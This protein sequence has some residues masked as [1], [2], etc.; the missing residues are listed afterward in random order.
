[1][2]QIHKLRTGRWARPS[3][4]NNEQPT[5]YF[6]AHQAADLHFPAYQA[7]QR[8]RPWR[9]L[10]GL[11]LLACLL[12]G[13]GLV[14]AAMMFVASPLLLPG[15]Q[16]MG[17]NVGLMTVND[18][19]VALGIEWQQQGL[20]LESD[21]E[22]WQMAPAV[23]GIQLDALATAERAHA[24]GRSLDGLVKLATTGKLV[25]TPVYSLDTAV[26]AA[27]LQALAPQ[28]VRAPV[29]AGVQVVEGQA[30]ATLAAPGQELN[31]EATVAYLTTYQEAVL[32]YGRLPLSFTIIP[33]AISDVSGIIGQI[34]QLLKATVTVTG[35]DPVSGE[36]LTWEL[37]PA[38]WGSWVSVA[39]DP[40][41]PG[42]W[43]W[44]LDSQ[45]ARA[46]WAEKSAGLGNGRYLDV[47][48]TL[49]DV[50]AALRHGETAV[51]A[52]M[53]HSPTQ[54]TVQY[55]DTLASIGR[56][57]GIPYPWIQQANPGIDALSPGQVIT[58]PSPDEMLPL[59]V[60]PHKRVI[61]SISRQTVQVFENSQLK[62]DWSASTGIAS[63]PTAPGIFQVQS[64]EPNAYAANWNLWMPNFMG[65]YRPVPTSDFMN[66]FHGF[67][68][69]DGYNLLWTNN[70][71]SPVTYGCILLSNEN[72]QA[73][74]AWA[75]AGVVVEI[76]P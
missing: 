52:R 18:T 67:P 27:A 2:S 21:T 59:P 76:Q 14:G 33:P 16:V 13:V 31:L 36:T 1:M 38:V 4:A 40:L 6:P 8:R 74:Y 25:V 39:L 29:N 34:N 17:T 32:A 66:G 58:V 10:V 64:H 54:Y 41:N 35:Y 37:P 68:T 26:S 3:A 48:E 45:S 9:W 60:V 56:D 24:A 44:Q 43:Q 46:F 30:R 49:R 23:I 57:M 73:L 69:R 62:W 75:E 22:T 63:S 28:M 70:L 42:Q 65:I 61:V 47:D 50:T 72:A 51:A 19:A 5:L 15:T 12:V 53:Y 55:G 20:T 71:G 7:S 11:L